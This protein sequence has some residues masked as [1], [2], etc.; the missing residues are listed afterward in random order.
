MTS[1]VFLILDLRD[2]RSTRSARV[3][4]RATG[5]F[6]SKSW[7]SSA[8]ARYERGSELQDCQRRRRAERRNIQRVASLNVF[9][10]RPKITRGSTAKIGPISGSS[11]HGVYLR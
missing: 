3:A 4:P 9:S 1:V 5:E 11:F 2:G 10:R 7:R 8:P 6:P